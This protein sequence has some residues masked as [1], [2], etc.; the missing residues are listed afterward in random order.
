MIRRLP[1]KYRRKDRTGWLPNIAVL[2][3]LHKKQC[4][5]RLGF[6]HAV[7]KTYGKLQG[8]FSAW[9]VDSRRLWIRPLLIYDHLVK[10][11][12]SYINLPAYCVCTPVRCAGKLTLPSFSEYRWLQASLYGHT[13]QFDPSGAAAGRTMMPLQAATVHN[14][15]L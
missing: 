14:I 8:G 12:M 3:L 1:W 4:W 11:V 10:A 9:T 6:V 13:I 2:L 5:N 15:D 7:N